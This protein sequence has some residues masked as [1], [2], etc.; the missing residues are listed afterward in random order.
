MSWFK[1]DDGFYD[2][3][4]IAQLPNAAIG[5]WVKCG[6][7][8][9]KHET[10]GVITMTQIK[11]LKGTKAQIDALISAG[12]WV[13]IESN[14]RVKAYSFHDW[15]E[16]QP[17]R[18]MREEER[19]L[20]REKKRKS[21]GRKLDK[22]RQSENVPWGVPQMSPEE[23]PWGVPQMS[24][25]RPD[26]TRPINKGVVDTVTVP[27]LDAAN[28]PLLEN[29][30]TAQGPA[31]ADA[32]ASPALPPPAA[33]TYPSDW[34]TPE[35]P[36]CRQHAYW[37]REKIPACAECGRARRWFDQQKQA[38]K[39]ARKTEIQACEMCDERGFVSVELHDGTGLVAKCDHQ[40]YPDSQ[41]FVPPEP[42]EAQSD[43]EY[44]KKLL[45]SLRGS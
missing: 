43:P 34:S 41:N 21:R 28:A 22:L 10:D 37:S 25:T 3:P 36:R 2:H 7:W 17:T 35:D 31:A 39:D 13:Q 27:E 26:P 30:T 20:W 6:S 9:A 14:L 5:L 1:I 33:G 18:E 23:T 4:K 45:A 40:T 16:Y 44:R 15:D 42:F 24:G 8:C 32:A 12:L 29:S 11:A 19:A 38:E